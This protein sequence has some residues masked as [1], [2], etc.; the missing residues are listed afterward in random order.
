M[1]HL[2]G[3]V[4]RAADIAVAKATLQRAQRLFEEVPRQLELQQDD[5]DFFEMLREQK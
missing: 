4:F 3:L 2:P 1:Q 5:Q